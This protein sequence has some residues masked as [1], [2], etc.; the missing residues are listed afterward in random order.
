M[1]YL[2]ISLVILVKAS[3]VTKEELIA[4]G[5]KPNQA[6]TILHDA[7]QVMVKRGKTYWANPRLSVAPR[8]IVETVILGI[9]LQQ[10][11][12]KNDNN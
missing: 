5:F 10:E 7:R 4:L 1:H 8:S 11:G 3:T 6:K 12:P 9:P 2:N